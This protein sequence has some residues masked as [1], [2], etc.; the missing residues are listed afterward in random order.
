FPS[1]MVSIIV[2]C[3]QFI[4]DCRRKKLSLIE[5]CLKSFQVTASRLISFFTPMLLGLKGPSGYVLGGILFS[6]SLFSLG[7]ILAVVRQSKHFHQLRSTR[8][9][10]MGKLKQVSKRMVLLPH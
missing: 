6:L 5:V 8:V 2:D 10:F 4:A 1:Q 3:S 7:K 9:K